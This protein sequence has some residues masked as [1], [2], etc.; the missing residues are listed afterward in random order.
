LF[1]GDFAPAASVLR[2]LGWSLV[3]Y[4]I[5][6]VLSLQL[7]AAKREREVLVTVAIT[8]PIAIMLHATLITA[9]G[10]IGVGEATIISETLQAAILLILARSH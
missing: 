5:S 4:V 1:G 6:A 10:L 9:H 2:L 7:V 3:P 8:L